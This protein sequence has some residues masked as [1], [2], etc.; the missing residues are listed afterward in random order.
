[1]A[2][3][4]I[5]IVGPGL[6]GASLLMALK[7]QN[8]HAHLTAWARNPRKRQ[9]CLDAG[10]CD[11]APA[12]LHEAV[13]GADWV[14]ICLPV[15]HVV[16][17]IQTVAPALPQGCIVTD[18]G[19]TKALICEQAERLISP[20]GA[21]FVGSHPMAGGEQSGAEH[22]RAELFKGKPVL[23]TPL[24]ST[25]QAAVRAVEAFWQELGMV[26]SSLSAKAHDEAIAHVSHLPHVL[27]SCLC[28][29]LAK[30]PERWKGYAGSG[31][32]DTTRIASGD[33]ELWQAIAQHN[34][35]GWL[36]AVI[37]F[38]VELSRMKQALQQGDFDSVAQ[39]LEQGKRYRDTL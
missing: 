5:T 3:K 17:T 7:Q 27:A 36:Q 9:Q 11:A 12:T 10:W 18:V 13:E 31:L 39:L 25:P 19:S 26:V 35:E 22:A 21:V 20:T 37:H 16:A 8:Q 14:V 30:Q 24:E 29:T 33:S 32:R 34:R 28:T 1:M 6:L 23:V 38:E 15:T 2:A 4:R